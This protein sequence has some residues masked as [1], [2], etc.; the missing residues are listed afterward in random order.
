MMEDLVSTMDNPRLEFAMAVHLR[1]TRVQMIP[2]T[3]N[4]GMRGASAGSGERRA[5]LPR[6]SGASSRAPAVN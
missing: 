3:P 2:N 5:T 6:L 4:G 1:F